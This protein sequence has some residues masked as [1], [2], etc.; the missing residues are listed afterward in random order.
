MLISIPVHEEPEVVRHQIE[1]L[2]RFFED[3]V[4][5]LHVSADFVV[6][7]NA[8]VTSERVLVNPRRYRTGW[9][10]GTCAAAHLANLR[11]GLETVDFDYAVLAASNEL[12][13]RR[14]VERHLANY[15][16]GL[17]RGPFSGWKWEPTCLLDRPLRRLLRRHR[18]EQPLAG[19]IEG[20]FFRRIVAQDVV[21]VLARI[22]RAT[23]WPHP[24]FADSRAAREDLEAT[25]RGTPPRRT[26]VMYPREEVYFAVALEIC[27]VPRVGSGVTY[28]NWK[29]NLVLT[30]AEVD[31]VANVRSRAGDAVFSVKAVPRRVDDPM[32]QYISRQ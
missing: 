18:L 27:R 4:V 13:V 25:L 17:T 30:E 5:V 2:E 20:T 31:D 23:R 22:D 24:R 11:H 1:N 16:A 32:R 29:R 3:P 8:L 15:D 21:R 12:Y 7:P 14:G 26:P 6:E 19:Q 9:G 10:T 28:M